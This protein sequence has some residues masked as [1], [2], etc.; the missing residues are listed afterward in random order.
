MTT[1]DARRGS[2]GTFRRF[3]ACVYV[4][5]SGTSTTD[6]WRDFLAFSFVLH[7]TMLVPAAFVARAGWDASSDWTKAHHALTTALAVLMAVLYMVLEAL[8]GRLF[9]EDELQRLAANLPPKVGI[10]VGGLFVA[11]TVMMPFLTMWFLVFHVP[12]FR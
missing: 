11:W 9:P 10:R 12:R 5:F 7:A 3:V 1:G 4:F 8:L 2:S 6:R